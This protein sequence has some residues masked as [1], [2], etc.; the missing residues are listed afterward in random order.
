MAENSF[1]HAHKINQHRCTGKLR[2]IR[3]CPTNAIRRYDGKITFYSDLCI[4]CGECFNSCPE[5]VFTP[6]SDNIADFKSFKFLIA[7]PS[8]ILYTQFDQGTHPGF[9]HRA[10]KSI[11]FNEIVDLSR[12]CEEMGYALY[13]HLKAYPKTRPL[14]SSFCPA[15]V[16]FI[17]VSYPNLVKHIISLEVPRELAA[18]RAKLHFSK[19]LGLKIDEIGVI[20]FTPCPA[21]VVSIKQPAEKEKSWIDRAIPINQIYNLILSEIIKIQETVSIEDNYDFQYGKAWGILGQF[22]QDVGTERSLSVAGI[23]HVRQILN[24][25]ENFKL[26]SIDFVE[27]VA[28]LQGCTNGVFCVKNPYLS[29]HNFIQIKKKFKS[30]KSIPKHKVRDKYHKGE[31]FSESPILPRKTRSSQTNINEAIKR[32][33]KKERILA[34]LP[35]IDCSVCGAPTC[36]IFAED[37]ARNEADITNCIF[38]QERNFSKNTP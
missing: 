37:C 2:C 10:L 18:K 29:R 17:Q 22:S 32:M 14:I 7:L 25:I 27:A 38:L 5:N 19:K 16:R 15:I 36:E 12:V 23:D 35:G 9:I 34:K 6:I 31:Y 26:Q 21:K 33:K 28:C 8:N 1:Y 3:S 11:G 20:Y 13:H 4:D 30:S 24:D